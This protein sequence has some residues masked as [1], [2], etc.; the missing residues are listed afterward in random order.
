[1]K[2]LL[3]SVAGAVRGIFQRRPS[4]PRGHT[5]NGQ[6]TG[7]MRIDAPKPVDPDPQYERDAHLSREQVSRLVAEMAPRG[8]DEGTGHV[9]DNM[10]NYWAD[11]WLADIETERLNA[12]TVV[13]ALVGQVAP[14]EHRRRL[15]CDAAMEQLRLAQENHDLIRDLLAPAPRTEEG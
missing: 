6:E 14:K 11:G 8:T 15:T 2:R 4:T 13:D 1:M 7:P 10:I 5:R 12:L 9:L 3:N